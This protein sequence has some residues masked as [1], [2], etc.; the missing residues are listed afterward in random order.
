MRV[1]YRDRHGISRW[2]VFKHNIRGIR[3]SV[4]YFFEDVGKFIKKIPVRSILYRWV[5][6]W[7]TLME[8]IVGV[9]S[10]TIIRPSWAYLH[11]VWYTK[12]QCERKMK[13]QNL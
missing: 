2:T 1:R 13:E 11:C 12:R 3:R 9:L 10:F 5:N 6:Y 4:R 8:G 7:I